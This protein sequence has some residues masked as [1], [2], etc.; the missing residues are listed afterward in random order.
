MDKELKRIIIIFALLKLLILTIVVIAPFL[1]IPNHKANPTHT[2]LDGFAQYDALT[3]FDIASNGYNSVY[4]G[5]GNYFAY[6]L[7]PLLIKIFGFIFGIPLAALLISNIASFLA[8]FALYILVKEE[9]GKNI[10]YKTAFYLILFP[11]AYFLTMMYNESLFLLL[12]VLTFLFAKRNNWLLCGISGFLAS[13]TRFQGIFLFLPIAYIYLRSIGFKL[14]N[15]K[16]NGIYTFLIPLGMVSFFSY[17]YLIT[18]N[19]F[20]NLTSQTKYGKSIVLPFEAFIDYG[21][22]IIKQPMVVNML[23][24]SI[25]L[26]LII[27]FIYL[28]FKLYKLGKKEYFIYM[29][30]SL[31]IPLIS[32]NLD[33][34]TRFELVMFPAFISMAFLSQ[35][36]Q[37]NKI[38]ILLYILFFLLMIAFTVWH[39][40]GGFII[41]GFN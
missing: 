22:R 3:Y 28:L 9:L 15:I 25:S 12:T 35:D 33:A 38:I 24:F 20:I 7:Y 17:L 16:F 39:T 4:N 2:I 37:K 8:I 30:L 11:T 18:G 29:G 36:P 32:S 19:F 41:V 40:L 26:I 21:L 13:L 34:S 1:N 27:I 6:P 14:K 10:A 23:Y 31:L 5:I